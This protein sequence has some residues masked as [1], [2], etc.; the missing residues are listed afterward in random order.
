MAKLLKVLFLSS[1]VMPFAKTGGLA[2]VAGALPIALKHAGVD[3][4][5]IMPFYR[6]VRE[7]A[8]K[9]QLLFKNI[10]VPFGEKTLNANILETKLSKDIPTYLV[11]REDMFD[12]PHLYGNSKGDYYDNLERF[13]YFSHAALKTAQA[14][15]F[16]PDIIHCHDWQTGLVP[17]LLKG[18]YKTA[19]GL[20]NSS[21][22]FTI[23]NMGYQGI[24]TPERLAVTGLSG[25]QFFHP[26]GLEYWG[27]LSLLKA[28]IIYSDSVTTVS[29]TYATEI[30]THEFGLGMEGVL[31]RRNKSLHGI[32][33]GIDYNE[34]DPS[35]D[36]KIPAPFSRKATSGKIICKEALL[37]EVSLSPFLMKRPLIGMI[38][39]L[40][41]QKGLDILIP[42]LEDI[43]KL[44]TGLVILGSGNDV[45]E[46]RLKKLSDQNPTRI[47]FHTGFNDPLAHH[48]MAGSDIFLI[49]SHYEP[50]GLTQMYALK[51]GTVPVVR[52]TG[53]LNDTIEQYN[54]HTNSGN[55]FKFDSYDSKSFLNA[56][57]QAVGL[58]QDRKSWKKLMLNCMKHNFSWDSS[59]KRYLELY[60]SISH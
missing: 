12:R 13:S 7:G 5:L 26:E 44:D 1:E 6:V 10:G 28:G 51:Y 16:A 45:I 14:I 35:K 31:Q 21:T 20:S 57:E 40:D 50:C 58:F 29:P 24:F 15:G 46:D 36:K 17:A 49:P 56:V 55:G 9:N 11:E 52:S 38:S 54:S 59:A 41:K 8:Y 34:W 22:V 32:L 33:N 60:S 27:N 42:I 53:G 48:I 18:P 19:I 47:A 25:P 3:V 39:R 2:D 23:H 4:R 37:K 30:M 43:V